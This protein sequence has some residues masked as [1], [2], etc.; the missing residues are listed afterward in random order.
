MVQEKKNILKLTISLLL[1]FCIL[2][3]DASYELAAVQH[4]EKRPKTVLFIPAFMECTV[5]AAITNQRTIFSSFDE[6]LKDT[7]IFKQKSIELTRAYVSFLTELSVR[8]AK[9]AGQ[10]AITIRAPPCFKS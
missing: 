1:V 2:P 9:Y 10:K 5:G 8:F 4:P 3:F 7:L 6:L